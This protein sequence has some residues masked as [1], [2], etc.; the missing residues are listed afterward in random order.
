MC[1]F[2]QYL[3]C[4]AQYNLA[5]G[6]WV[7]ASERRWLVHFSM[8]Q[9]ST[10]FRVLAYGITFC[11]KNHEAEKLYQEKVIFYKLCS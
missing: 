9:S 4:L 6:C 5:K 10:L 8:K 2:A 1:P 11:H 3:W 7:S